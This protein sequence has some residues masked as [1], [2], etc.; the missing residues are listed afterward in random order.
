MDSHLR[1]KLR[2]ELAALLKEYDGISVLVTHDRDEAY[3]LCDSM[4]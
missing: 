1:E 3:Q 4:I 2:L